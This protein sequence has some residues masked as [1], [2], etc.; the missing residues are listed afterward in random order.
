[1]Y[2]LSNL[3]DK[4]LIFLTILLLGVGD[5][6]YSLDYEGTADDPTPTDFLVPIA[7]IFNLMLMVAGGALIIML[8]YGAIKLSMALGKPMEFQGA[9]KTFTYAIVGFAIV[10]GFFAIWLIITNALGISAFSS[11]GA[12]FQSMRDSINIFLEEGQVYE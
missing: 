6:A 8:L 2:R 11:P 3:K 7:R 4:I 9:Q 12:I 5:I 10:A 1:M